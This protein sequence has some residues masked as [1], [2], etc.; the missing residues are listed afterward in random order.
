MGDANALPCVRAVTPRENVL[1]RFGR[2]LESGCCEELVDTRGGRKGVEDARA[3]GDA[4]ALLLHG[5][6]VVF[7]HLDLVVLARNERDE[8]ASVARVT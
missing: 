7:L 5:H 2:L 6:V 1:R 4:A 3:G 8:V